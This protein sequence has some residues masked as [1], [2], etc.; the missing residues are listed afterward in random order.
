MPSLSGL[1]A[2]HCC[3]GDSGGRAVGGS[4][5]FPCLC[6]SVLFTP[7]AGLQGLHTLSREEVVY[8]WGL[9]ALSFFALF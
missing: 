3:G 8:T 7:F 6:S 9:A 1:R 5:G 2:S 4:E